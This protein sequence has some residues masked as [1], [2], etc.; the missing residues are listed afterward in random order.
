M[1]R[2][3]GYMGILSLGGTIRV[4]VTWGRIMQSVIGGG[5]RCGLVGGDVLVRSVPKVM[6]WSR[7]LWGRQ[8]PACTTGVISRTPA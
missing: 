1:E 8:G 3:G 2:E 7:L 6:L 4:H 5:R